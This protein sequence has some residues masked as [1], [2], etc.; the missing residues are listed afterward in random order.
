MLRQ[1][2]FSQAAEDSAAALVVVRGKADSLAADKNRL[3]QQVS[4]CRKLKVVLRAGFLL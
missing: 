3:M 4:T 1:S 2:H